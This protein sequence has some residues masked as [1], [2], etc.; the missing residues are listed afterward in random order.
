[1]RRT[2][3]RRKTDREEVTDLD[4]LVADLQREITEQEQALYSDRILEEA[5]NPGNVGR[6]SEPTG[7]HMVASS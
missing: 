2:T 7:T 3:N 1:M 6:M 5:H 4:R